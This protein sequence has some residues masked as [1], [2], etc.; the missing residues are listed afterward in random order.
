MTDSGPGIAEEERSAIYEPYYRSETTALIPGIGLGLA[1]SQELVN[2]M[3]GELTLRSEVNVGSSF[4][5]LL[6]L[7]VDSRS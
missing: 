7:A 1:I 2:Q 4:A 5:V 3:G 6:P